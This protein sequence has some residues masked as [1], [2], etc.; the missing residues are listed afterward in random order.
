MSD[1][2]AECWLINHRVSMQMLRELSQAALETTSSTRGGRTVGQQMAHIYAVRRMRV[3]KADKSLLAALPDIGREEGH[4]KQALLDAFERSGRAPAQ[5]LCDT[6]GQAGRMRG[7]KRGR[8]AF[9]AYLI[10]HEAHHRGHNMLTLKLAKIAR[11][12]KIKMGLWEWN[13]I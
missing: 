10:A 13:R 3:E 2:L 1:E 5:I 6:A 12:E 7:F 8:A 11:S 9:L 4:D